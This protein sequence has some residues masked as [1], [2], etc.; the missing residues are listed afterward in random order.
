MNLG[1]IIAPEFSNKRNVPHFFN[2]KIVLIEDLYRK[3]FLLRREKLLEQMKSEKDPGLPLSDEKCK[4]CGYFN[5]CWK[6][7]L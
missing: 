1:M 6:D 2:S 3:L 7:S 5:H 4:S